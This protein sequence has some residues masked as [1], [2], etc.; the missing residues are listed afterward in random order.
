MDARKLTAV[1]AVTVL[2]SVA[3]VPLFQEDSDAVSEPA[4]MT[5]D[6]M[7]VAPLALG[8]G[9]GF[10]IGLLVG[11][12]I[13]ISISDPD[14]PAGDQEAI[15]QQCRDLYSE[16][17]TSNCDTA[18]NL[19]S[20]VLPADAS[21]WS[22][23]ST[24]WNRAT[25]LA[26]AE[27]WGLGKHYDPNLMTENSMLRTNV[28]HYIYDWQ[29]AVD[30]AYNSILVKNQ[31]LTGD[32]YGDMELSVSWDGGSIVPGAGTN[33]YMDL[34]Q[35]V[36]STEYGQL[37]YLHTYDQDVGGNYNAQTSGTLYAY[38]NDVVMTYVGGGEGTGMTIT[39][40]DGQ[41]KDI[42][43]YPS[44][45]YRIESSGAFLAG[46]LSQATDGYVRQ[47]GDELDAADVVGA[48]L[49]VTDDDVAMITSAGDGV[50]SVRHNGNQTVSANL[51][52]DIDYTGR[53]ASH[54]DSILVGVDGDGQDYDVI[55]DWNDLIQSINNVVVLAAQAG[56][57][58]WGIFDAAE[59]SNSF[60]SPSSVSMTIPGVE[61]STSQS[62]AVYV[63]A[64]M[65]IADYWERNE[66]EIVEAEFET[67]AESLS[68][69]IHGDIYLNG[70]LFVEDAIITPYMS[71]DA[72]YLEKGKRVEW[73]GPGFAMMWAQGVDIDTF[74]PSENMDS[75]EYE[76]LDMS[77]GY[78]IEVKEIWQDGQEVDS[79][80]LEPVLI[81]MDT[82]GGSDHGDPPE[83]VKVMNANTL[84]I[85]IFML[86]GLIAFLVCE[87]FGQPVIGLILA[88]VIVLIGLVGNNWLVNGILYGEWWKFW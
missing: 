19:I 74:D 63:Q 15:Y 8:A 56:D 21:L 42:T 16:L 22:F 33:V 61:L 65:Q 77:D 55:G 51:S 10:V 37:V 24:Y 12:W 2:L 81:L 84:I 28:M 87:R 41:S 75:S 73:N 13:G 36:T 57:V 6:S 14:D 40:Q 17:M 29:A 70:Q 54:R 27:D 64:M 31:K 83:P 72:Q 88:L 43:S 67:N 34:L 7:V 35:A 3:A 68:V 30:N 58:I 66:G 46:P 38:G 79:I 23:T 25:E 9:G 45:L 85:I 4:A 32:C 49:I 76:L 39:V 11:I 69:Y 5:K 52:I 44:G 20:S 82:T 78:V 60:V 86:V 1:L 18:L 59:E 48:M 50:V 26:V 47:V 53:D 80:S 71:I 62:Q